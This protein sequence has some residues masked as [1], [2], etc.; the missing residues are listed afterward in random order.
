MRNESIETLL[1]RHYGST[2]PAPID[3]EEKLCHSVRLEAMELD[4]EQ[5]VITRLRERRVSRRH[6]V[7]LVAIGTAGLGG[8]S[9]ALEGVRILEAAFTGQDIT[10][11]AYS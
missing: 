2:A 10:K 8:L 11:P 9:M 7:R 4:K 6:A 5:Q 1:L 3:L